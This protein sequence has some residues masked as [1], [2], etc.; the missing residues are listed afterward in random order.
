MT[1]SFAGL[2]LITLLGSVTLLSSQ[3]PPAA[4]TLADSSHAK[5]QVIQ[6]VEGSNAVDLNGDGKPDLVVLGWRDNANAHGSDII[7]F[8]L[9]NP[10]NK[11][12]VRAWLIVPL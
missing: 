6:L 3:A 2:A 5:M 8:Y 7:T 9:A 1:A 10:G 11:Y 4:R 12:I